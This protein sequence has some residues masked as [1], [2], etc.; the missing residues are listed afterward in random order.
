MDIRYA[1]A[2]DIQAIIQLLKISLGE[3]LLPK[4]ENYWNWKHNRNP[5]G[6]SPVIIAVENS[7]IVGVRAFMCWDWKAGSNTIRAIRAVD[8]A[9]HPAHQGKGIFRKLTLTLLKDCE[10][11]GFSLVFNTPNKKSMPGY[12]KM[13]WQTVGRLPVRTS[14]VRPVNIA[15]SLLSG[16]QQDEFSTSDEGLTG[17]LDHPQ[18]ASLIDRHLAIS[19][20]KIVTAYSVGFLRWRYLEVPVVR[21]NAISV[22]ENGQLRAVI[23]YRLKRS[24]LGIEFRIT[25]LIADQPELDNEWKKRIVRLAIKSQANYITASAYLGSS[26]FSNFLGPFVTLKHLAKTEADFEGFK[27]WRPTLGDMELF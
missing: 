6:Q 19:S 27:N 16:R 15:A 12:L 21:Y 3:S 25:D 10:M 7:S 23:F 24:R 14:I 11:Q 9:T 20:K 8:T 1:T 5:F 2:Q 18:L 17:V 13:G 26:L 4:S 22:I